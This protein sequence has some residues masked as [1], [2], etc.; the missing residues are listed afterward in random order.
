MID[1]GAALRV[2]SALLPLIVAE[3]AK[4]LRP[5]LG[6]EWLLMPRSAAGGRCPSTI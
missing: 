4:P 1:R 2:S 5:L 6:A 3:P